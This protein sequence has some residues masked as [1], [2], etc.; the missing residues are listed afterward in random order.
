M[1]DVFTPSAPKAT[2]TGSGRMR[3]VFGVLQNLSI[4]IKASAAS[5][6]LL[7]CLLALGANAYVTSMKSAESL[8]ILSHRL[9]P[10]LQAFSNLNNDIVATHIKIFRY[11][12]WA[13]NS[14]SEKLLK[15]LYQEINSNIAALSTRIDA[16]NKRPDL[17]AQERAGLKE[18][19]AKWQK[20]KGQAKDTIDVGQTDAAMAT[21]M[22]G[23]TD[24]SFKAVDADIEQ[25]SSE[26]TKA[27]NVVRA[28][29]SSNTERN[30][31]IIVFGTVFGF[32]ISALVTYLVGASIVR[33]IKSVT[34]VMQKLS[35]GTI[36]VEIV[37]RDRGDEIGKMV[38]AI[39]VF[40]KNM[41]EMHA[42]EQMGHQAEQQRAAERRAEMRELADEFEKSVQQIAKELTDAVRAMHD[43]AETMALI[44][45]ETRAKSQSIAGTVVDTQANVDS[46]AGASDELAHSIEELAVQTHN[47]K[48]LTNKTVVESKS[49][50][51]NV[52]QLLESVG[53]IV[54]ITGLIQAIAQQ[55]N[56]LALNATI[57]AARAGAAG[58]GFAVVAAEVKSLAQQT[59]SATEEINR[60][61]A[62]VNASCDAVV[63]IIEQVVGAIGDLGEGT[64]EMAAAVGQQASATQE[65]S[66]NVQQAAN[67]SR[68]VAHSIVDLD[69][70]TRENDEASSQALA[71][72]KRLLNQSAILQ[73]Q[74][75]KFLSHVRAA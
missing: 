36:D 60:K 4:Q 52:Q 29:L 71:G 31:R 67:T 26:I 69:K 58:K 49:A 6:L 27:A 72:A 66:K 15:T 55:T 44:A 54:P 68:N 41:I 51:L 61:I 5:A 73:Q 70:K 28:G 62:A 7:I 42:M 24:D 10:K 11:V 46:V 53:Q 19:L 1:E 12:S 38:V 39:D 35:T 25:M 14:V 57:E 45:A 48:E 47:A 64:T 18:L 56:L 9:E 20:C 3:S 63:K 21:M 30:K 50:R 16:L 17:S 32:L 2:P 8:R 33:P 13:S 22:L 23:Q 34:D 40:R 65:I 74:V 75:D 37:H 43:N 59:A